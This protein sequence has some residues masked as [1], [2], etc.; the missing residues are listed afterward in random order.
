MPKLSSLSG[1]FK[2]DGKY[3]LDKYEEYLDKLVKSTINIQTNVKK[4]ANELHAVVM[5]EEKWYDDSAAEFALWWNNIKGVY[6][7]GVDRLNSISST[8]EELVRITA[9]DVCREM[10]KSKQM[11]KT[12]IEYSKITKFSNAT[13]QYILG[14]ENI[15]KKSLGNITPTKCRT[16]ATLTANAQALLPMVNNISHAFDKMDTDLNTVHK[17]VE[18]YLIQGKAISFSGLNSTVLK[19]KIKK[20]KQHMKDISEVLYQKISEDQSTSNDTSKRIR[21]VL[22]TDTRFDVKTFIRA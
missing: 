12:H 7:D 16:G 14:I 19:N 21:N 3:H 17:I 13:D 5:K 22:E 2:A 4:V 8:V 11:K 20:A 10:K 15:T 9:V 18:N 6:G 1:K